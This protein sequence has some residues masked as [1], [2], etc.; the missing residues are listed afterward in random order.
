MTSLGHSYVGTEH[1]LLGLLREGEGIAARVL[2]NL[3][4]DLDEIR[5]EIMKTLDP[6]YENDS[7]DEFDSETEENMAGGGD[8]TAQ[9]AKSK[10]KTP[11]LNSFGRDL[12]KVASSGKL[13]PVIGRDRD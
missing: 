4:V 7:D 12:T 1:I 3:G 11:A 13:D 6:E 9:S 5:Y 10:S 8:P 2:E